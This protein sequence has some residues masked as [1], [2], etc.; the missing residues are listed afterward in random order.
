MT[1]TTETEATT[2]TPADTAT[3]ATMDDTMTEMPAEMPAE[4][5]AEVPAEAP[6]EDDAEAAG[7]AHIRRAT[8]RRDEE[9]LRFRAETLDTINTAVMMIDR[10]LVIYYLNPAAV[11][12][13]SG[14]QESFKEIWPQFDPNNLVGQCIDQFLG[15][16]AGQRELL[17]DP[18]N[19]PHR[20]EIEVGGLTFGLSITAQVD[21]VGDYVGSTMVW[22]N[23]NRDLEAK[24]AA[25]DRGQAV[26]EFDLDGNV[27]YCNDNFTAAMG[28][29]LDEIKGTHH[30]NFVAPELA[31]S[32]EYREFWARLGR[33]EAISGEFPRYKK[34]GELIWLRA[35]YNP[36][37]NAEGVPVKFFKIADDITEQ[38]LRIWDLEGEMAAVDRGQALI[39]FDLDGNVLTCNDNFTAAMG[40]TLDEIKGR[41]HRTLVAPDLA[42]SSEYAEFWERLGRGEAISGE[43]P[44]Y[45]KAGEL[46]W[47]RASYNPV[48]DDD[49]TPMKIFKIAEDITEQ[50]LRIWDLEGKMLAVDRGQALIEFDL[51][52]NVLN[53]NDNFTAA[54]GYTLD[55]VKGRHHRNFVA[56]ELAAS[57]E[58]A[59]FWETLGRGEPISGEF[60]RYTKSG[61]LVWLGASYNP[62]LD[63]DG[64]PLK[65]F[66]IADDITEQRLRGQDL[67]AKMLAVD[68]GQALIEFDLD[69]N[70]L[71]CNDNFT[72]AMGYSLD[73]IKGTH[74]R[75]FVAPELAASREYA[76]F[77]E[78]LG[79]G[80]TVAGEFPRY[81]KN[82]ELIWLRASYSPVLNDDGTP[83]K[84][85]KIASDITA[86]RTT[87]DQVEQI[88]TRTSE[89]MSAVA[90][91]DLTQVVEGDFDGNLDSLQSA[92]NQSIE[93]LGGLVSQLRVSVSSMSNSA[94]EVAVANQDLSRR[95]Q[96]QA[97]ALQETATSMAEMTTTVEQNADNAKQASQLA[98]GAR[99]QAE[100]GGSVVDQA[101]EA[102][103]AIS[104]SSKKIADIIGVIDEIAFQTNLLALNAAV[105][106]ARAGDQGRGFAVVASEVRN[107]A[108]RS[109]AAAKEIKS[110]I[111]DSL[112]KVNDGSQLVNQSGDQLSE[113]VTSVKKVSDIVAE[114]AAASEEQS[115]AIAEVNQAVSDMDRGTQQNAAMVEE[116][117]AASESM[118]QQAAGLL[119]TTSQFQLQD[120]DHAPVPAATPA[121]APVPADAGS[122]PVPAPAPTPAATAAPVPATATSAAAAGG[123]QAWQEF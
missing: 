62:V 123:D 1:D 7:E 16:P 61:E 110:L 99:E 70:V 49:G 22:E 25:V 8:D 96:S 45:T 11:D 44:R 103:S 15:D 100:D 83:V 60:P 90:G 57:R 81:K 18:A 5:A 94:A 29:S 28:Y 69:G 35:S 122:L 12:L 2:E 56:P 36:V 86:E 64:T 39:E 63:D 118:Q 108:Q 55:E 14:A 116:A 117:A 40:Y 120:G 102:M 37:L 113:I 104:E 105:E 80:E 111:Q 48:L 82:G 75:N 109:A 79:R 42:A 3:P 10:D 41:H 67:E 43:F 51:D 50:K 4:V 17:D 76:E 93:N 98:V 77:W 73:E 26:I 95:T 84:F 30:R 91:G 31:A 85:F 23:I 59:E 88:V 34:N 107:L 74:H 92:T 52:G 54:M 71:Y 27:L 78:T 20:T 68:R 38:K 13:M 97:A 9:R 121:T 58:Y 19:L 21:G 101:V 6:A 87:R 47:L 114:I 53:C 24:M 72:A 112:D 33:G 65:V 32:D 106:A 119:E 46:V 115:G 89:V 66:K